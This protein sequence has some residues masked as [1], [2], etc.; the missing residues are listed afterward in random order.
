MSW[1][2]L[3]ERTA[4]EAGVSPAVAKRVL[5]AFRAQVVAGLRDGETVRVPGLGTFSRRWVDG[6]TARSPATGRRIAYDGRH[7]ARFSA[8]ASLKRALRALTP[9]P[10][11]DPRHQRA[12]RLAEA[13][14]ADLAAYHPGVRVDLGDA[15]DALAHAVCEDAFGG[16]WVAARERYLDATPDDVVAQDDYLL[17][18]AR[19]RFG[20]AA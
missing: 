7:V 16:A 9:Q 12:L 6:G 5:V 15:W 1:R 18:A 10:L 2:E 19:R 20:A 11:S 3:V 14:V 8:S 17:R 4:E 13:L